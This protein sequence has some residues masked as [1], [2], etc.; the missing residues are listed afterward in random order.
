M[1]RELH[2]ELSMLPKIIHYCW[3]GKKPIPEQF[4]QYINGWKD[5]HPDY[6]FIQWDENN[7]P[8]HLPYLATALNEQ[9][10]ANASNLIRLWAVYTKGGIYLDTDVELVKNLDVFLKHRCFFGKEK[11]QKRI[12]VNNAVMGAE[13]GHWFV[14][15]CWIELLSNFDGT[16]KANLSS[17]ILTTR[18]LEEYETVDNDA[19]QVIEDIQLF[20]SPFFHPRAWFDKTNDVIPDENTYGI[21][22]YAKTWGTD[23]LPASESWYDK[24]LNKIQAPLKKWSGEA[25]DQLLLQNKRVMDG[26]FKG[27]KYSRTQAYGSSV[28]PKLAGSYEA[29]LHPVW[30][31]LQLND[32]TSIVHL[33]AGEGYYVMGLQRLLQ[34]ANGSIAVE[35]D[36]RNIALLKE[37][38]AANGMTA[39]VSIVNVKAEPTLLQQWHRPGRMLWMCDVE[40][41]EKKLFSHDNADLWAESDLVIELHEYLDRGMVE[42]ISGIFYASHTI[43]L[44]QENRMDAVSRRF[45]ESNPSA[46]NALRCIDEGRPE[47]MRW[48]L[49]KSRKFR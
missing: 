33:G 11:G 9:N 22:H 30:Y 1:F 40:G 49:I 14:Q 43:Q 27:L 26:P 18:L 12:Y 4:V 7:A 37:N 29:C 8:V 44:I 13:A 31:E 2:K 15:K 41:D 36:E 42:Y 24:W 3:F 39:E 46:K 20:S 6:E 5:L 35:C 32:Y 45:L 47:P 34:P 17:P 23:P 10:W 25:M 48:A 21:H 19:T 38:L 28:L 16:E